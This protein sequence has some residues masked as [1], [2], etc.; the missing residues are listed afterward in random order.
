[1]GDMYCFIR[2]FVS[3]LELCGMILSTKTIWRNI[4]STVE[5]KNDFIQ[6]VSYKCIKGMVETK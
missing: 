3:K 6:N 5:R 1:M 2:F 4:V